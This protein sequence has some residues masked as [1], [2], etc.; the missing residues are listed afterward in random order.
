MWG[1][2]ARF[3][4]VN[5]KKVVQSVTL[6]SSSS[7]MNIAKDVTLYYHD[8]R[9][10]FRLVGLASAGQLVFWIYLAYFQ[11]SKRKLFENLPRKNED[12]SLD[13]SRPRTGYVWKIVSVFESRPLSVAMV[14]VTFGM[15]LS[16]TGWF[17]CLRS[18]NRLVLVSGGTSVR[19][20]THTPLGGTH[21]FPVTLTD[22]SCLG[23]RLDTKTQLPLKFRGHK[24]FFI[25]DKDGKFLQPTLFDNTVGL[26]RNL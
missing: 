16:F 7:R 21:S 13:L 8:R 1:I 10:F 17:Y 5:T 26:K 14:A 4:N 25:V 22:I 15:F 12:P 24:F 2:L 9:K 23:S 3:V 6:Y 18:V 19:V 11:Y 20:V